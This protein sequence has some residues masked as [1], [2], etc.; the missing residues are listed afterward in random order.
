MS[1]A[2]QWAAGQPVQ[3]SVLNAN[4]A[5]PW[6]AITLL[7]SWANYQ[8]S[9][10]VAQYRLYNQVTTEVVGLL[11]A[12]TLT[13]GTEIFALPSGYY[14]PNSIVG[15]PLIDAGSNQTNLL[16]VNT[17]GQVTLNDAALAG[18]YWLH[19]FIPLDA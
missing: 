14:N 17:N 9:W 3:A 1:G 4:L 6:I 8:H 15:I 18:N 11:T 19:G 5:Q 7:N 16:M 12:G 2:T 10:A 13:A